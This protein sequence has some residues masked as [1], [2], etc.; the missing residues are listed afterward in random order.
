[1]N[2]SKFETVSSLVDNHQLTDVDIN[3]VVKDNHLSATWDRYHLIGD[4]MRNDVPEALQLDLS[5]KISNAIA[6]EPTVL[7][8]APAKP[9][10]EVVKA[11]IIQ[12]SKPFGQ[13]A[14]A[15]SAA[16]LMVLGVQQNVADT[17]TIMPSPVAS[18]SPLAGFAAPVSYNVQQPNVLSQKQAYIEQQRRFQALLSDHKQQI[19][20]NAITAK[21]HDEKL[22]KDELTNKGSI[23]Q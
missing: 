8:P 7:S 2:E 18:T 9:L 10:I 15:A 12:F 1:M 3:E 14:I 22:V 5:N 20:L 19:K 23:Q 13:L 16:G 17:D 6:E 11:K 4:V 21:K